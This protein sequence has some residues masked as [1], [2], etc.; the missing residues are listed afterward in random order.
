MIMLVT[1]MMQLFKDMNEFTSA[2]VDDLTTVM[3]KVSNKQCELDI[4]LA[5]LFKECSK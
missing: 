1:M 3:K 4:L 5:D 2:G